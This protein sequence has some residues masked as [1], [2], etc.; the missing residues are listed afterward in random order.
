MNLFI[1]YSVNVQFP[2]IQKYESLTKCLMIWISQGQ[3]QMDG[4]NHRLKTNRC[5]IDCSAKDRMFFASFA[6]CVITFEPIVIETCL[7]PQNDRM[8]LSFVK[9]TYIVG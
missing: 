5:K 3:L 2:A 1:D 9:D 4:W 8:S 7:A 6:F